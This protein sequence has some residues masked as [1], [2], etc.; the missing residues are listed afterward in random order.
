MAIKITGHEPSRVE[1]SRAKSMMHAH[2]TI[3]KMILQDEQGRVV[4]EGGRPLCQEQAKARANAYVSAISIGASLPPSQDQEGAQPATARAILPIPQLCSSAAPQDALL[5][6]PPPATG[7]R[8]EFGCRAPRHVPTTQRGG[9]T[10]RGA[11]RSH[12]SGHGSGQGC[13]VCG[14]DEAAR[15]VLGIDGAES[16]ALDLLRSADRIHACRQGSRG[17]AI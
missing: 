8:G 2:A 15:L 5:S 12:M 4:R 1:L 6:S 10:R 9:R 14:E 7:P 13:R 17:S 11:A 3:L 16:V